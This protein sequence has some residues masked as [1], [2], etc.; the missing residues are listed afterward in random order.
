MKR[1]MFVVLIVAI[2]VTGVIANL[3]LICCRT[4]VKNSIIYD[5]IDVP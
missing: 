4:N 5:S 1:W 2:S 3:S